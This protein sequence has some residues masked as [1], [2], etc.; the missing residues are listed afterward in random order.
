MMPSSRTEGMIE[1]MKEAAAALR[2]SAADIC[3]HRGRSDATKLG[4]AACVCH[5][6]AVVLWGGG[7]H[8]NKE[9]PGLSSIEQRFQLIFEDDY[10][11]CRSLR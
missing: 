9:Y 2:A 5:G 8:S 4:R 11:Y 6:T 3:Q 7:Y 1:L 10:S